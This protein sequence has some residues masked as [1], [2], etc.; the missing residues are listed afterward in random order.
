MNVRRHEPLEEDEMQRLFAAMALM[1]ILAAA[2]PAEAVLDGGRF[3]RDAA[4]L[5][6][7]IPTG[8]TRLLCICQDGGANQRH[9]GY[10]IKSTIG[11]SGGVRVTM[12][13]QIPTLSV[14]DR[15]YVS[16]E[17]C[18]TFEILQK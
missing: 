16:A 14:V 7:D 10:L 17:N 3:E 9:V 5:A 4:K 15:S 6:I 13:C 12:T 2:G 11:V 18:A 1:G 8:R